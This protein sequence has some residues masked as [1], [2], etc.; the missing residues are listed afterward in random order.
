MKLSRTFPTIVIATFLATAA[1]ADNQAPTGR[2]QA[3]R[4]LY[5]VLGGDELVKKTVE[6]LVSIAGR[7]PSVAP[8]EGIVRAWLGG[9]FASSHFG[10]DMSAYYSRTFTE[11]E[12]KEL[13]AFLRTPTGQ[14]FVAQLPGAIQHAA[15]LT[16][17][18]METN[19]KSLEDILARRK[20]T[21][22]KR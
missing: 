21:G 14:K 13:T 5:K 8:Y 15:D 4:D 19:R 11:K 7:D 20:G 6:S 16:G 2:E 9:S 17:V 3:G 22:A 18:I 12:L 10:E 1:L